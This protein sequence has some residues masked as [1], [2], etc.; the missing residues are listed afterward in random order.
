SGGRIYTSTDSGVTWA[1]TSAPGADWS[2]VASSNDGSRLI[3]AAGSGPVYVSFDSG[4]IW[5]TTAGPAAQ[6]IACSSDGTKLVAAVYGGQI[7]TI[8]SSIAA[9][10]TAG[11]L[12]GAGHTAV[13]LQYI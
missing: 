9:T 5:T 3:A 10:G 13:E 7:Y 6:S 2:S 1:A 4:A 12:I 8:S 11:Y